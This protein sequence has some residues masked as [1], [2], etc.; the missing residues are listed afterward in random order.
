MELTEMVEKILQDYPQARDS[1]QWLTLKI[2]KTFYP[3]S[4][5]MTNEVN[6]KVDFATIMKL[7]REDNVKRIRAK[8]QNV[9]FKYLPTSIEVV[10]RRRQNE[11]KW[12]ELM[13]TE[14]KR[15]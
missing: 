2:W 1:D 9:L 12:R 6:P 10:K 8:F 4:L 3:Q 13:S 5:D 15:L 14:F 7:P 11:E